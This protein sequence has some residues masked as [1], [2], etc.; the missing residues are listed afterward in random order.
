[1]TDD[2]TN[3]TSQ[4]DSMALIQH[5]LALARDRAVQIATYPGMA[6]DDCNAPMT[7]SVESHHVVEAAICADVIVDHWIKHQT[8]SER[9]AI[10]CYAAINTLLDNSVI[11]QTNAHHLITKLRDAL[12]LSHNLES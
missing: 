9:S 12:G 6:K 7:E 11:D 2:P 1:M 3:N 5:E 10:D 8:I 4:H